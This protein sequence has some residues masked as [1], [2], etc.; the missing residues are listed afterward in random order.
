M[1]RLLILT[2]AIV[3]VDTVFFT[4]LVPLVPYYSEEFG[5]SKFAVGVVNGSFGAG[6]LLGAAPGAVLA[7]RIGVRPTAIAGLA[8]LSVTSLFFGFAGN[9]EALVLLRLGEGFGSAF[10]WIAAFTWLVSAAPEERRGQMIG[11][12][13]GSAVVGSLLGPVVGSAAAAFG[14]APV[15]AGVAGIGALTL[16]ATLLVPP[17]DSPET[18]PSFR[19]LGALLRPRPALGMA[20]IALSPLL[21]SILVVLAPLELSGLGWGAAA[22]GAV[23]LVGAGFEATVHPLLGRVSD[24]AGYRL[25]VLSGLVLSA[26]LLLALPLAGGAWI[27]ALLVVLCA[28]A[29]N[30]SLTPGTALFTK[31][32]EQAGVGQALGFGVTNVAWASGF[33]IGAP[34]G[35]ALSDAGGDSLAYLTLAGVCVLALLWVRRVI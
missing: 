29:F 21:F 1:R 12:L 16:A 22:I 20:L 28:G 33:A 17:P 26:L 35:G 7:A 30:F 18:E 10:S 5:L 32:S 6:I 8:L 9:V 19:S 27:I 31:S 11:T 13:I 4:A 25:P 23:F 14:I 15:L 34:V 2:C 24:R 3:L